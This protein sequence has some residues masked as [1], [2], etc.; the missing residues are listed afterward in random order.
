MIEKFVN[1]RYDY[2]SYLC[3]GFSSYARATSYVPP[4]NEKFYKEIDIKQ[5]ANEWIRWFS[6]A[7]LMGQDMHKTVNQ[8]LQN[9]LMCIHG[10]IKN[11]SP[12]KS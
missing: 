5:N 8:I 6:I 4:F 1:Y 2:V 3:S 10:T 12:S 7:V 11:C 9:N